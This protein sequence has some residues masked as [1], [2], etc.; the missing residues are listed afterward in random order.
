MKSENENRLG[1]KNKNKYNSTIEIIQ[2][3]NA[4]DIIVS[5]ENDYKTHTTF[6]NFIKGEVKSPYDKTICNIGC[7]GEGIHCK[8]ARNILSKKQYEIWKG[9]LERCYKNNNEGRNHV[10]NDCIVCDE[11]HNFQNFA[12]WYDENYYEINDE[13]MCL[14]KDILHKGNK[15]YS[16]KT[17]VFVPQN[18]N[19]LFTKS[20]RLRGNCAIGVSWDKDKHLY[21][22]TCNDGNKKSVHLGF[23]TTE[24]EAF[25]NY[26]TYKEKLIKQIADKYK[27]KIPEKLY[28]AM[29]S[30]IVEITD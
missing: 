8:S 17:C 22:S 27:D 6:Q 26:K 24:E 12:N 23:Y 30:Y 29:H 28:L 16:T 19:K 14:D 1:L 15:I 25:Y 5:F 7:L 20:D 21:K 10:Y 18:I 2:Y 9:M 4:K 11:W 13:K 3:N